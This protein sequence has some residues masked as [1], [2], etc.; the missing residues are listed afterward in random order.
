MVDK[1]RI[2]ELMISTK[3]NPKTKSELIRAIQKVH[4]DKLTIVD[5]FEDKQSFNNILL[6]YQRNKG[7]VSVLVLGSK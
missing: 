3:T 2:K 4:L 5:P 1:Q 6:K 7:D